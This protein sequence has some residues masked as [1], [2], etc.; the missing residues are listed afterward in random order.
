M[1][2]LFSFPQ[3]RIE[4]LHR[5]RDELRQNLGLR[6]RIR[7]LVSPRSTVF[8]PLLD[9]Q[10]EPR[11]RERILVDGRSTA[12]QVETNGEEGGVERGD[13]SVVERSRDAMGTDQRHV[14]RLVR[15]ETTVPLRLAAEMVPGREAGGVSIATRQPESSHLP[16]RPLRD[17]E[18]GV[19]FVGWEGESGPRLPKV[20]KSPFRSRTPIKRLFRRWH[21]L[22][23]VRVYHVRT[24]RS[25]RSP[26]P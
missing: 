16:L 2:H 17:V 6:D 23:L 9:D 25:P 7:W 22:P 12:R 1:I 18:G 26:R 10:R 19:E 15:G 20:S 13:D 21:L 3:I 4:V 8:R 5:A 14:R 11:Q 24:G